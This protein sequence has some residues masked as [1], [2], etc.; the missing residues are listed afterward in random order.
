VLE[1][2]RDAIHKV[3][4][5]FMDNKQKLPSANDVAIDIPNSESLGDLYTNA[6]MVFSKRA[7][8][9]PRTLGGHIC[10]ALLKCQFISEA[11]VVGNGFINM[12]LS[13]SAWYTVINEIL[14][15]KE[16]YSA[17]PDIGNGEKVNVEFVSANPTG[18]LHTGHARNAVFGSVLV[19]LLEKVGYDVTKEF[20]IN[21]KGNQIK[22]LA[23]SVYLRYRECLGT[24]V[25]NSN[26][27]ED[28]YVGDYIKEIGYEVACIYNNHF[29]NKEE[30]EWI[31]DL[32]S[33]ASSMML[34][35]IKKDLE[36]LGIKMD[37]Y[38]S[39][40]ELYRR[41]MVDEALSILS[42]H[43]DI[44]EGMIPRPKGLATVDDWE[45]LPQTLFRS[46]RY[47]DDIDRP[48]RKSDGS[49]TYFAGDV[50]YHLDKIKRGFK[51]MVTVL[52][53]DHN[54]YVKRL[55][56]AVSALSNGEASLEIKLYQ[57]V[58]F[59]ENGT[60][61]KMSKR[62]GNFITLKEVVDMVGRDA[63]RFMMISRDHDVMID[64]D[65]VKVL[66]LSNE[67]P[68][69]YIQYAYARICSVFRNAKK[70]FPD[71]TEEEMIKNDKKCIGD[72]AE[73]NLIKALCLWPTQVA[74]AAQAM[75]PHRI[76][77]FLHNI[78]HLIH[79]LWNKGK[80]N[81]QLR[82]IEEKDRN[83]TIARLAML[84]SA[85]IVIK[86]GLELIGITPLEE[87]R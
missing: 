87:L 20:Y 79:A 13:N 74:S 31:E 72:E 45:E 77:H 47:G 34:K 10:E 78:A 11:R 22:A 32:G 65:L 64:F 82:F 15:D 4:L 21:D 27:S 83:V 40:K 60:Q 24:I 84:E 70:I 52:G 9:S 26:F 58:N 55:K 2:L 80:L 67:N 35:N 66:E 48:I 7:S 16:L 36:L 71:I 28:M 51:K 69:F 43:G 3:V 30:S 39:E 46:V 44:Y 53:A 37:V 19:N 23:R 38:T 12:R 25:S 59:Y 85:R 49:W 68:L 5:S 61:V 81:T 73:I 1:V 29:I 14:R 33:F 6:A 8:M 63:T 54:G 76:P 62:S 42:Y 18:P 17:A 57:L 75:E 86:D 41:R 56:A 50:A